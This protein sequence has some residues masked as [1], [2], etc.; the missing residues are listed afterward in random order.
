QGPRSIRSLEEPIAAARQDHA[1]HLRPRE[2]SSGDSHEASMAGGSATNVLDHRIHRNLVEEVEAWTLRRPK[3]EQ[4]EHA[5]AIHQSPFLYYLVAGD[6][7]DGH[8]RHLHAP[9]GRRQASVGAHMRS[10]RCKPGDDTISSYDDVFDMFGEI[11]KSSTGIDDCL[12]DCV[13]SDP[14][15]L[16]GM[17][18]DEIGRED[19]IHSID[20][21][22]GPNLVVMTQHEHLGLF[23]HDPLHSGCY[24]FSARG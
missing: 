3:S 22:A 4:A 8:F 23:Q 1:L 13:G 19:L 16:S 11:G 7:K 15:R 6:A 5:E 21:A 9:A 20:V 2:S 17:V 14:V 10:R 18:S 24:G 12:F